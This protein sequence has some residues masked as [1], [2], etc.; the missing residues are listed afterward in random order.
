MGA[1]GPLAMQPDP[2]NTTGRPAAAAIMSGA[3]VLGVVTTARWAGLPSFSVDPSFVQVY[4]ATPALLVAATVASLC[5]IGVLHHRA[6][7]R[8]PPRAGW[9][10]TRA[11]MVPF[12]AWSVGFLWYGFYAWVQAVSRPPSPDGSLGMI[13]DALVGVIRLLPGAILAAMIAAAAASMIAYGASAL[14]AARLGRSN[15]R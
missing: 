7:G 11:A 12:G 2:M 15:E 9:F 13:R 5:C 14:H 6:A 4:P 3:A 8:E 1:R 10:A